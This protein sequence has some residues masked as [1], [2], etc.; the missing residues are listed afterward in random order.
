VDAASAAGSIVASRMTASDAEAE[1]ACCANVPVE[2]I[3]AAASPC[4]AVAAEKSPFMAS[5]ADV[6][7]AA[8]LEGEAM[9][10]R[11]DA[12]GRPPS[13]V[14]AEARGPVWPAAAAVVLIR[15]PA[16]AANEASRA[17][18]GGWVV[19]AVSSRRDPDCSLL[20]LAS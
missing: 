15:L 6:P 5:P 2:G 13:T 8:L 16:P 10:G 12:P 7:D 19:L 3:A 1:G 4:A 9:A 18:F 20:V 11:S 14:D 17:A